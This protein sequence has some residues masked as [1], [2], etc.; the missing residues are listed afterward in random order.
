MRVA[1][2]IM[3]LFLHGCAHGP[4]AQETDQA[5]ALYS[6]AKALIAEK[7]YREALK[8]LQKAAKLRVEHP[9]GA[10]LSSRATQKP[11]WLKK[12]LQK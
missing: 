2:I 5:K 12:V 3:A 9:L 7:E 1:A 10:P 6:G 11:A 4:T 8:D